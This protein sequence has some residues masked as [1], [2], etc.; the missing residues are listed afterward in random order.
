M[1]ADGGRQGPLG[2]RR[3]K[4]RV[5]TFINDVQPG[6]EKADRGILVAS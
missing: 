5:Y 6:M 4:M 1:R 3:G 2:A